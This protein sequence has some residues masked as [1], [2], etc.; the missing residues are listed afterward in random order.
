MEKINFKMP[1][2]W[3]A[4]VVFCLAVFLFSLA[5]FPNTFLDPD[6]FY[7]AKISE[8]IANSGLIEN[9]PWLQYSTLKTEFVDHHLGFHLIVAPLTKLL[10]KAFA[11]K[12]IN[13]F[14]N[15]G[16]VTV[17]FVF[18]KKSK[19]KFAFIWTLFIFLAPPLYGRLGANKASGL[20]LLLLNL[21][22]WALFSRKKWALFSI[23]SIYLWCYG[24]WPV[25]LIVLFFYFFS[26]LVFNFIEKKP[27]KKILNKNELSLAIYPAGGLL[28]AL[29]INP[30]FPENLYFYWQQIIQIG[31]VNFKHVISVGSEW[32]S[33][34]LFSLL[35]SCFFL[36]GLFIVSLLIAVYTKIKPSWQHLFWLLC[37]VFFLASTLKSARYVEYFIPF[38]IIAIAWLLNEHKLIKTKFKLPKRIIAFYFFSAVFIVSLIIINFFNSLKTFQNSHP[39][40]EFSKAALWLKENTPAKS[41]VF[42]TDWD[43]FP[44]LWFHNE[45]NYYLGGLD[46]TFNYISNKDLYLKWEKITRGEIHFN[47]H[48]I[49]KN[50]Y[51]ADYFFVEKKH[52][53]QLLLNLDSNFLAEKVYEDEQ[54]AVYHLKDYE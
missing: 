28:F 6:A 14:I 33:Y 20:A 25:I 24:G 17:F 26:K 50:E 5:Q 2:F 22:L 52:H 9:F 51:N 34:D 1:L 29:I 41:I 23:S 42:H 32:Y 7:H 15:S 48:P 11:L 49:V 37:A 39:I 19:I 21:F 30:Y 18:L 36:W 43:E 8:K 4:A 27:L 47:L 35:A 10:D 31:M 38:F 45:H 44:Q 3:Q 16:F 53:A 54:S 40:N 12:L 46:P 13:L